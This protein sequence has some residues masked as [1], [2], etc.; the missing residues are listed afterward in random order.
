MNGFLLELH[1]TLTDLINARPFNTGPVE[2]PLQEEVKPVAL[3]TTV[4]I[5]IFIYVILYSTFSKPNLTIVLS[6]CVQV[7]IFTTNMYSMFYIIV[8]I[9][10]GCSINYYSQY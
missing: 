8:R 5:Y 4:H 3:A 10:C 7:L 6:T 9:Y 1:A 2:A